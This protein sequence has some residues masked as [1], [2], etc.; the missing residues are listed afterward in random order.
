MALGISRR[1]LIAGLG[2][3][4]GT[5]ALSGVAVVAAQQPP[6]QPAPPAAPADPS[7][8]VGV[9]ATT[10]GNRSPFEQPARTATGVQNSSARAP[11]DSLRGIITPSDLHY[12]VDHDT[13]PTIDPKRYTLTIHGMVDRP[14]VFTLD[15]LQRFP[16]VSRMLFLECGGNSGW[17]KQPDNATAQVLHGLTS[18]SNWE[19]VPVASLLKEAGVQPGAAWG[20][21]VGWGNE[22]VARSIPLDKLL[23]DAFIAYGQNG[24]ALRPEQGYPARLLLP[25]WLGNTNIKWLR[26]IELGDK[27]WDT[28]FE[29]TSYTTP[30]PDNT[31]RQYIYI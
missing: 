23:D 5:A 27:P 26:R 18:C 15:D 29:T 12:I 13:T 16:S 25:G 30:M 2:P 17:G 11:I 8:V 20:L 9:R 31:V 24:E 28:K 7:K 21:S 6:A 4:L 14:V 10:V 22:S 1:A 3:V 19:G